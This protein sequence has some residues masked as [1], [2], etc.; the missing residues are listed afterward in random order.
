MVSGV[1]W[2]KFILDNN[3]KLKIELTEE[4]KR[5]VAWGDYG[6]IQNQYW[7]MCKWFDDP[8]VSDTEKN[9]YMQHRK[10]AQGSVEFM[11]LFLRLAGLTEKEIEEI[12]KI[13][14]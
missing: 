6:N 7:K 2:M 10:N 13:P 12:D 11:R 9:N 1:K 4:E 14:F 3:C 5:N 8:N